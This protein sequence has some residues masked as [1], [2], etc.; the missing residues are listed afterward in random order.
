VLDIKFPEKLNQRYYNIHFA[1]LLGIF[2]YSDCK[3]NYYRREDE[4]LIVNINNQDYLFDYGDST[5]KGD[6]VSLFKFK[7]HCIEENN[8]TF[9]FTPVSFYDWNLYKKLK[10]EIKYQAKGVISCRQRPYGNAL[11]RRSYVQRLLKSKFDNVVIPQ[12]SHIHFLEEISNSLV[13]VCVPGYSNNILDRG[14]LQCLA[15]GACTISPNL[16][17]ILPYGKTLI[18][19]VH[20]LECKD[21]YS[22]LVEL[23]NWCKKNRSKCIEIG[24]NAKGLFEETSTPKK[25]CEWIKGKL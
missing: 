19:G 11:S 16:P 6:G 7:F 25:L 5:T 20:Y 4:A 1:Y 22:D 21:N 18:A 23:I 2:Q 15:L 10:T 14:Q 17:E 3:I 13:S 12:I 24:E 9:A 8:K